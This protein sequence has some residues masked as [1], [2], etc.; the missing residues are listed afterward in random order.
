[1]SEEKKIAIISDG[2]GK[3][4][5]RLMDAVL[6][7]YYEKN[8]QFSLVDTF[9]Q[10]R[11]TKSVNKV[12]KRIKNDYL[13]LFSIISQ[14]L[15]DYVSGKLAE[16]GILYLNV[17]QPMLDVTS[18]FLGVHPDFMPG[19]LQIVNDSYY[20]K[21]DAIGYAVDHDDGR[22]VNLDKADVVLLGVSR[23]C[24]TPV[25][26]YLACN[27]G[28]SVA[29]IPIIE[30][31][32]LVDS[33]LR[34]LAN[35]DHDRIMGLLM[36]PDTL[37]VIRENRSRVMVGDSGHIG[38]LLDYYDIRKV[39][40]EYRFSEKLFLDHK[41]RVVDVTRRAIEEISLDII[42]FLNSKYHLNRYS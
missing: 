1:M 25:S 15:A 18:K 7:Q 9:Q 26:M 6:I 39:T 11:D 24:K 29:N 40:R 38:E 27:H 16:R 4:A 3:T 35:V 21:V 30:N 28:L 13:V 10:V 31:S 23:T 19:R 33:M 37:A 22:G 42:E 17:L 14:D 5:R 34:R 2:T 32:I 36:Q 41:W 12:L 8:I 20:K